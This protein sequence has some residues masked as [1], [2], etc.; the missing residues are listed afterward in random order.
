MRVR[1]RERRKRGRGGEKRAMYCW[2]SKDSLP[3]AGYRRRRDARGCGCTAEPSSV[4]ATARKP[5]QRLHLPPL[6]LL[7]FL[8][9]LFLFPI[10]PPPLSFFPRANLPYQPSTTSLS[11]F[12][13]PLTTPPFLLSLHSRCT[14]GQ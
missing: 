14:L 12:V 4:D 3:G 2:W 7:L 8:F 5:L 11:P 6:F 1:R 9:F 10:L 13:L